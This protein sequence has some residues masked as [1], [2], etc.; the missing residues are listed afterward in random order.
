M[1]RFNKISKSVLRTFLVIIG[2]F[3]LLF[4]NSVYA[5][6]N[7]QQRQVFLVL[8]KQIDRGNSEGI[9]QKIVDLDGYP[10]H[11]YLWYKW[12]KKNLYLNA[13]IE[14]FQRQY[15]NTRYAKPL[16]TRQMTYFAQQQQWYAVINN[17]RI[18]DGN[19][20]QCLYYWALYKTGQKS[21][22]MQ[23]AAS[24]W[25]N[26]YSL[27]DACDALLKVYKVSSF[28]TSEV[29]WQRFQAALKNRK[30]GLAKYLKRFFSQDN[31]KVADQWLATH[32][33]PSRVSNCYRWDYKM[34]QAALIF[35][36]GIHRLA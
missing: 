10:L 4:K 24:L 19:S 6:P 1:I 18:G 16:R 36:H 2:C 8:E 9:R 30:P 21:Q 17:Y 31:I 22:A 3:L 14:A 35:S 25:V 11:A 15:S 7:D 28:L 26:G 29:N 5:E 27:P 23:G 34:P 33:N 13:D 12:L 32:N 20:Q